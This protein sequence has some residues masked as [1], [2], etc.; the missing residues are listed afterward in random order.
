MHFQLQIRHIL[1]RYLLSLSFISVTTSFQF[2]A[3][4]G[5]RFKVKPKYLN[6]ELQLD[7]KIRATVGFAPT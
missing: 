5:F 7:A 1:V 4:I 2:S 6:I 3:I